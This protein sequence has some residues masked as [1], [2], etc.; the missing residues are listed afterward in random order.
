M[1]EETDPP[2]SV[3]QLILIPAIVT[4]LVIV[5]RFLGELFEGPE[6]LFGTQSGGLAV[7]G[8]F[9]LV[10]I[11]GLY[12][13]W[14]L[15]AGGRGPQR[16]GL[17]ALIYLAALGAAAVTVLIVL[18][19][20]K[21]P[22]PVGWLY[23]GAGMVVVLLIALKAWPGL[24][25]GLLLY[26]ILARVPVVAAIALD[27]H[28]EWGTHYGYTGGLPALDEGVTR[29][30]METFLTLA[31]PQ[32]MLMVPVTIILGGLVGCLG[33]LIGGRGTPGTIEE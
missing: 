3:L 2:P 33:A 10:P 16:P 23:V 14:A 6:I 11:V 17:S 21:P 5:A 18:A 28:F 31:G 12:L 29:T 22:Y 8:I 9:W 7:F 19:V 24:T 26:G 15:A 13:G 4:L 20:L 27:L 30:Y 32:I 25:S 1:M